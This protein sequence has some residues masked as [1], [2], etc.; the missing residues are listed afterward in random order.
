M[1][2]KLLTIEVKEGIM[3]NILMVVLAV[4]LAASIASAAEESNLP[5]SQRTDQFTTYQ[6]TDNDKQVKA[7][8]GAD[9]I[10]VVDNANLNNPQFVGE[11]QM[12]DADKDI[13]QESILQAIEKAPTP[14]V[15]SPFA[16]VG[17]TDP[18][19]VQSPDTPDTVRKPISILVEEEK[20][21]FTASADVFK[22]DGQ[23]SRGN[24]IRNNGPVGEIRQ[25]QNPGNV[26][27]VVLP[28]APQSDG[29]GL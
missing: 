3:K 29:G 7:L 19:S 27:D 21:G 16:P 13:P 4:L 18:S 17:P 10:P 25:V 15:K 24:V 11:R 22:Y 6:Q 9:R 26:S 14:S 2:F 5:D 20:G 23:D 1:T 12:K 28:S 8:I